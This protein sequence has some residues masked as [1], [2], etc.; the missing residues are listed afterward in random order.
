[1]RRRTF[2]VNGQAVPFELHAKP[3]DGVSPD[4]C[5]RIYFDVREEAPHVRVGY[6]GRHFE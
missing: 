5:V 3:N 4:Q 2:P 1:M 6:V